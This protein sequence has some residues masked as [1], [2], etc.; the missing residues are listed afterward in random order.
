MRKKMNLNKAKTKQQHQ[1]RY[2]CESKV[3]YCEIIL[4]LVFWCVGP[5]YILLSY[6]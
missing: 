4:V 5:K 6:H 3:T 2:K 1:Q